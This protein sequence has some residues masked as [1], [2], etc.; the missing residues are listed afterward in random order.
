MIFEAEPFSLSLSLQLDPSA[1]I[2]LAMSRDGSSGGVIY[3]VT[4]TAVGVDHRIILGSE[5]P[6]FY[7]E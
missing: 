3:L 4:I 2:A 6:K 1:A 7:D 5:L